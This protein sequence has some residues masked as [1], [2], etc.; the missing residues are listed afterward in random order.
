MINADY[1]LIIIG[2]GPAGLTAGIYAARARLN[3][4]LI[5]KTAPGGQVLVTDMV[6]N[7]PGF[8]GG[9]SGMDL[10]AKMTE[11]ADQFGLK[12]KSGDV[13][14][15]DFA[16]TVKTVHLSDQSLTALSV[17]VAT[18]ASPRKLEVPGEDRF[19]GKGLSTCATCDA[20]F[21][22]EKTVA[23]VGGGDTA[24]QESL[25]LTRFAKKVYLIHRRDELRATAILQERAFVNDKIEILW[26]TIVTGMD[27]LFGLEKLA[28]KNVKTGEAGELAVDGCFVWVGIQPNGTFLADSVEHDAYGFILTD[29]NM[30]S[31]AAGIFAAGDGRSKTVRQIST[32]VGDG[33]VAALSSEHYMESVR[34]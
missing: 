23:A 31:S 4:V 10:V 17:I 28:I 24:V 2:G 22:K 13:V 34:K 3:V 27:G 32:A 25:F 15:I 20:P 6:E 12:I 8:P 9:I 16:E 7:Y 33:A 1:D 18:G 14:A 21:Y 19:F 5:E 11:Q 30:E 29:E 26:D